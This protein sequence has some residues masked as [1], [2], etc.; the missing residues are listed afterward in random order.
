MTECVQAYVNSET[1]SSTNDRMRPSIYKFQASH[2]AGL[3]PHAHLSFIRCTTGW[4]ADSSSG[5]DSS[6]N[7]GYTSVLISSRSL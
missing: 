2:R 1:Y 6:G 3:K 5:L 7:S 4:K